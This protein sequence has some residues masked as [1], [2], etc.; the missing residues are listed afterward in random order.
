MNAEHIELEYY[1]DDDDELLDAEWIRKF[2]TKEPCCYEIPNTC[3]FLT[4]VTSQHYCWELFATDSEG[5]EEYSIANVYRRGQ[6]IRLLL[7]LG[8]DIRETVSDERP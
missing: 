2:T 8:V 4:R 3:Y 5:V 7:L 6:L 1:G